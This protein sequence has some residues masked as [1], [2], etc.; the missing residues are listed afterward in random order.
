MSESAPTAN[1]SCCH[2]RN[3]TDVPNEYRLVCSDCGADGGTYSLSV[4]HGEPS[5]CPWCGHAVD[6][7]VTAV[8]AGDSEA[9][10]LS[11]GGSL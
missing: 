11:D 10:G 2:D 5:F 8:V 7:D 6:G 4:P 3:C 1:G 9:T